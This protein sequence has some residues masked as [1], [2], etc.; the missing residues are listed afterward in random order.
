MAKVRVYNSGLEVLG[1]GSPPATRTDFM[2]NE[3]W[4][5]KAVA[6]RTAK[7]SA[8]FTP[9]KVSAVSMEISSITMM[10]A[11]ASHAKCAEA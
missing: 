6:W 7:L 1:F 9:S 10:S 2:P 3:W 8:S 4:P 5:R 11:R